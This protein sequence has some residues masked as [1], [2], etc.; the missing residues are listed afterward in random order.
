MGEETL[1]V[2]LV[3]ERCE[4]E[5]GSAHGS[6]YANKKMKENGSLSEE[7]GTAQ[8]RSSYN[9]G[10]VSKDP[11]EEK[12]GTSSGNLVNSPFGTRQAIDDMI[13]TSTKTKKKR[14]KRQGNSSSLE[15]VAVRDPVNQSCDALAESLMADLLSQAKK[16]QSVKKKK[17]T[18]KTTRR[19]Q[20]DE[21][22]ALPQSTSHDVGESN[23]LC[24]KEDSNLPKDQSDEQLPQE[25][26]SS[27]TTDDRQELLNQPPSPNSPQVSGPRSRSWS[28]ECSLPS[29]TEI[30]FPRSCSASGSSPSS[31]S[32]S[33]VL[34][35]LAVQT[36]GPSSSSMPAAQLEEADSGARTTMSPGLNQA[37]QSVI[38]NAVL[39]STPQQLV[40]THS[41]SGAGMKP[42]G[43]KISPRRCLFNPDRDLNLIFTPVGTPEPEERRRKRPNCMTLRQE[44][45]TTSF[46]SAAVRKCENGTGVFARPPP[47]SPLRKTS[48]NPP[49]GSEER[50]TTPLSRRSVT[51]LPKRSP[52]RQ[53]GQ[54]E[55]K[56]AVLEENVSDNASDRTRHCREDPAVNRDI[57]RD[58]NNV[59]V[60]PK[61]Q[62]IVLNYYHFS[63]IN[64]SSAPGSCGFH[65][66]LD[67][68][69]MSETELFRYFRNRKMS[70]SENVR[71]LYTRG[72]SR[73][74]GTC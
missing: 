10:F 13:E 3:Q 52:R 23:K 61:D 50:S 53:K 41:D 11:K 30:T 5:D 74:T 70:E 29:F 47:P 9:P 48:S 4:F 60:D 21:P 20:Q 64:Y 71:I 62:G 24:T 12:V 68:M 35:N 49:P 33:P 17:K 7:K 8:T 19:P 55:R 69:K 16:R 72:K 31:R 63:R 65:N 2:N 1:L 54:P 46:D 44:V 14:R 42:P 6:E 22:V 45:A 32:L 56:F 57:N 43:K 38:D 26:E 51:D 15:T 67:T 59:I 39:L 27:K 40:N 36:P 73:I 34:E 28:S 18:K 58:E 66:I 37:S 25:V